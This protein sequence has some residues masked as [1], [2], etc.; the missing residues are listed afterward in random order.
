M[1][2]RGRGLGQKGNLLT[3]VLWM[4]SVAVVTSQPFAQVNIEKHRKRRDR[5]GV[6]GSL[7][8]DLSAR[9]GNADVWE[10]GLQGRLDYA[11]QSL[12]T[13]LVGSGD[14]G[15]EGGERFSNEMLLHLRGV[16]RLRS[17]LRP[18][19]F[20][21]GNYDRSRLLT[22]RG[23]VG[24]GLR[25]GLYQGEVLQMWW[26]STYMFE[27]ERLDLPLDASH[28][29]RTSVHRWS[30]YLSFSADLTAQTSV[31]MTTYVQPQF[32]DLRDVRLL[33]ESSLQV[34]VSRWVSVEVSFRLFYDS[35]PPEGIC[36][37]DTKLKTGI[38]IVF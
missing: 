27:H 34:V 30:N 4:L 12:R 10:L 14:F 21:Q 6:G 1:I 23:L 36:G 29:R 22:L 15:W 11:S 24:G 32:G 5:V 3:I 37:T 20:M 31:V 38:G 35:R 17:S 19:V 28:A 7:H 16:Y 18:E 26:G 33:N 8:L 25:T 13:F 2:S 9:S